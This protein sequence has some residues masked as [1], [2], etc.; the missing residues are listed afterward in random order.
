MGP[1][2]G[3]Y[4]GYVGD[5]LG[6]TMEKKMDTTTSLGFELSRLAGLCRLPDQGEVLAARQGI[7]N[8]GNDYIGLYWAH[9]GHILG[10]YRDNGKENGSNYGD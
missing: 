8:T 10:L 6:G 5:I 3:S 2:W 1:E 7:L 9:I 4:R